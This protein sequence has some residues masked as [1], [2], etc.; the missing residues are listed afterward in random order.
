MK[1]QIAIK[2]AVF[3]IA[4]FSVYFGHSQTITKLSHADMEKWQSVGDGKVTV[5]AGQLFMEEIEGSVGFAV[6]SPG[7]YGDIVLRFEIM[8]LNPATVMGALLNISDIGDSEN[9]TISN[10]NKGAFGF[11]TKEIENYIFGFREMAHN[12]MPFI[13]KSPVAGTESGILGL[14][15]HEPMQSGW[16]YL[17]ECG[18]KGTNLWLKIDGKSIIEVTDNQPLQ[19]GKIGIRVRGTG[20]DLGKCMVRNIEIIG[21]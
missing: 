6:I 14:A 21:E 10:G 20:S 9:L 7:V 5:V 1:K 2:I 11:F 8:T 3:A 4:L 15:D 12:S 19:K 17:V 13:R 16:R 18:K